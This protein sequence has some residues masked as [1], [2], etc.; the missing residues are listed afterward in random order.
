MQL[1]NSAM[2]ISQ[3]IAA[4]RERISHAAHRANRSPQ[5][6]TL[7]AVTKTVG[8]ERIKEAYN[9]GLRVFGENRV[10]EFAAKAA[11]L[12]TLHEAEWRLIGH[13]QSNK[14]NQAAE[15]F[16]TVDS[17]DSIRLAQRLNAAAQVLGKKLEVLLEINIGVEGSKHGF[18]PDSPEL[19]DLLKQSAEFTHLEIRGLMAIPPF[20]EDTEAARSYF[21]RLRQLR[22][23]LAKASG[24]RL[25]TLSMGM[26]HDFEVAIEEGSTCVR[27]GMAIFGERPRR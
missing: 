14:T 22:D 26:S 18:S 23:E 6:I 21:R 27:I 13:L 16:N 4:I 25:D 15:L 10:Q 24:L 1:P 17:I 2:S 5:E 8:Y 19:R 9:A 7:M 12:Q 3:N 11:S 20:S